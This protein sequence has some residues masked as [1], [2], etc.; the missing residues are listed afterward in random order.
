MK[1]LRKTRMIVHIFDDEWKLE[2]KYTEVNGEG[3]KTWWKKLN[4]K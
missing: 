1:S 3:M 4:I 2:I